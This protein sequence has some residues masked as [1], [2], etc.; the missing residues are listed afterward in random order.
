[1]G[2]VDAERWDVTLQREGPGVSYGGET[3]KA[4]RQKTKKRKNPKQ[5]R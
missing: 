1:M 4:R 2:D 3:E 5:E